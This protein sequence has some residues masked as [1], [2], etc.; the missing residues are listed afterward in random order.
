MKKRLSTIRFAAGLISLALGSIPI[1]ALAQAS[2]PSSS[3]SSPSAAA[4]LDLSTNALEIEVVGLRNDNGQVGC[5]LFNDPAA[6]PRD[7]DKVVKHLW[8][9]IHN[10]KALC[11]FP[12]L[13]PGKY[14]AVVYHD[15]NGNGKFDQNAFGMPEEGYGF[16]RDAAALF[17]PPSFDAASLDYTGAPLYSVVD[18][19]Y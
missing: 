2:S 18:I 6:F 8:V 17:S 9:K 4:S 10:G 19:R 3:A 7:G 5:S 13:A 14:A 11:A 15:E 1:P 12:G 16:T